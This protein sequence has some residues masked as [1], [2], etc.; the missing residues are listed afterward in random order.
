[1]QEFLKKAAVN[2]PDEVFAAGAAIIFNDSK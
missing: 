2:L 1:M